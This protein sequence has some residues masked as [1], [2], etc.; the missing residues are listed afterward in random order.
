MS[1]T[2]DTLKLAKRFRDAGASEPLAETFA[3]AMREAQSAGLADLATKA[4]LA[5]TRADLKADIGQLRSDI[6]LKLSDARGEMTLVKWM[7]GFNLAL[8]VAVLIKLLVPSG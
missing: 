8:S 7:L 4:D 6:D 5:A 2:L 3:E 1:A